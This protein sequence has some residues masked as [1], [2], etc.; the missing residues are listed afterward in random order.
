[1]GGRMSDAAVEVAGEALT[2]L[3]ERAVYWERRKTLLLADP[4]FGKAATFRAN[5]IPVPEGSLQ[6][7]LTRLTLALER[8]NAETLVVLGDL[9]HTAKG[10]DRETLDTVCGWREAHP[11]VQIVLVR[12]NHD[13]HAGD[14]PD[15]WHMT[16]VDA[17]YTILP[18]IFTHHP[19][20]AQTGYVLAG[21]I[22]PLAQIAGKGKQLVKLPCFWFGQRC[23]ILPAFG[24][25]IDGSAVQPAP[26][27]RIFVI[28]GEAVLPFRGTSHGSEYA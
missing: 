25:F 5:R 1:M 17:P 15:E 9:L 20:E 23:G 16:C 6:A 24:S 19:V 13:R 11:D 12:G 2:L 14:P 4:H 7:D 27:D 28:A 22:H 21:H 18:F 26:Q 8:T 3:P 10:R